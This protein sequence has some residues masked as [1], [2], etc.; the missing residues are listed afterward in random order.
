MQKIYLWVNQYQAPAVTWIVILV[1]GLLGWISPARAQAPAWQRAMSGNGNQPRASKS[2]A[3]ATA[4]DAAGN[5][6][7]TGL[8][9]GE[10][11]FGNI[12]LVGTGANDMFVAKWNTTT[13][14]W[15]WAFAETTHGTSGRSQGQS[16]AVSGNNVY[17]SGT[18]NSGN[19]ASFAGQVLPGAGTQDIFLAKYTDNGPSVT[20]GWATSVGGTGFDDGYGVAASGTSV[21]LTG[22]FVSGTNASIAGRTFAGTGDTDIFLAKYTDN[23]TSFSNG[24]AVSAGGTGA[25]VGYGV[26]ASGATVYLTGAFTSA[27]NA[28]IAGQVL[29][30]AGAQDIFLAKY[31]DNGATFAN[32][33]VLS[34]GGLG[35]EIGYGVAVGT[36]GVY[37]TG[38]TTTSQVRIAG[39]S[40]ATLGNSDIYLA[41]YTDNGPSFSNGWATSGGSSG[42]DGGFGVT[43]SGSD[44]YL[45]GSI[46]SFYGNAVLAGKTLP[47][48][49]GADDV[50]V[51]K[52]TDN[53]TSFTNRWASTGGGDNNDSGRG[54]AVSGASVYVAAFTT[55]LS[56]YAAFFGPSPGLLTPTNAGVLGQLQTSDGTWQRVDAPLHGTDSQVQSTTT[57]ANGDVFITGSFTGQVAFGATQLVSA[58]N[59]DIFVAKW[60]TAANT[61][62]WATRAGGIYGESGYG[63]AVNGHS[64]YVTGAVVTYTGYGNVTTIAGRTLISPDYNQEA[65]VAK[66]IDNGTGFT[67]GWAAIGG[68]TTGNDVG[69][70]LTVRGTNV[71]VTGTFDSGKAAS[72][73]GQTLAGAGGTDAFLAKYVDNGTSAGNG[74]AV[75]AGGTGADE[76]RGVAAEG[77]NVYSTGTFSSSTSARIAGQTLAGAGGTDA[78]LAKYVDNG[79]SA[80]NGWATSGGGTGNDKATG[81]VSSGEGIY[82]TGNFQSGT[83]ASVSG[84]TLAGAGGTDV[85]LAKYSDA[86]A[87]FSNGWAVSA[88]GT[89]ADA[90][91]ALAL[92]GRN[93]YLTGSFSATATVAGQALTSAGGLD[94]FLAKYADNGSPFSNGWATS[95]GGP[96]ADAGQGVAVSGP[97]VY[98][99]GFV[100]PRAAFGSQVLNYPTNTAINFLAQVNEPVP[101][102]T[103]FT[104]TA[105]YEGIIVSLTGTNLAGATSI[106]FAGTSNNTVSTDFVVNATGTQISNIIV[107][108]GTQ[109]GPISV[110]TAGGTG[111]S[112]A[113]F[114]VTPAVP[115]P[116]PTITALAPATIE[117]GVPGFTLSVTGTGFVPRCVVRFNGVVLPTTLASST[118][119]TALVP[120]SALA[121]AGSYPVTVTNPTPAGGLSAPATFVVTAPQLP[122][123][124]SFSPSSGPVG[125]ILTLTG[126]NLART[127]AITFT[128]LGANTVSSG[129]TPNAA[130]TQL[131]GVVVPAGAQTGPIRLTTPGGTATSATSF[132]VTNAGAPGITRFAPTSAVAGTS[133]VVT[134]TNLSGLTSLTVNGVA[135]PF[136]SLTASTNTSFAFPV[137][138]GATATGV[139]SVATAA[140]SL[141]AGTFRVLLRP[142]SSAPSF[143]ATR[144]S[145]ANS[146]VAVTF[147][148]PVTDA[149]LYIYSALAGG[150]KQGTVT[151]NGSTVSFAATPGTPRTP[152]QAGET[153]QVTV[154]A[155]AHNANNLLTTKRVFQFSAAV[156]GTG[157]GTFLA[158]SNPSVAAS[159]RAITTGDVDG[160]GDLDLLTGNVAGN[161]VSLLL[162]NG[163]GAFGT[164]TS[165]AVGTGTTDLAL[166]DV[167]GDGDLDLLASNYTSNTVSVRL[168]NGSGTFSS[169]QDVAIP[170]NTA[171]DQLA[172]GDVDGDGDLDL[173]V[174]T[175]LNL[176]ASVTLRLNGGDASGSNT[177]VYSG[178]QSIA[179]SSESRGVALAD[180]DGDGD[181]D[182]LAASVS[183]GFVQVRLNGGDATGSNTGVFSGSGFVG[184]GDTPASIAT[185]DLDGDGDLDLLTAN[186][187]S[188]N[189]SVR[190][191]NGTGDF[192]NS[193]TNVNVAVGSGPYNIALADV[194]ADGDLDL[195]TANAGF[196]TDGNSV[197]V[198]LNGGNATG[199]NT[200]VFS[201][202]STVAVGVSPRALTVGDFD[203]DGD[204]DFATPDGSIGQVSVRLNGG[205]TLA[206]TSAGAKPTFDVYPNPA[207]RFANVI[208]LPAGQP[209]ELLDAV[210]RIIGKFKADA[211]GKAVLTWP[212][213]VASGVYMLRA[214]PQV[215][216]L[217]IE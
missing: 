124:S 177:G 38:Y 43:T 91:T 109:T 82:L 118:Q 96:A 164:A 145:L 162:N 28:N 190:F 173:L 167:D 125:T 30:G 14:T 69:Y 138:A 148:E 47:K 161:T 65:F 104:P 134:G 169:T 163:T 131:M 86:G 84:R 106:T 155:T 217:T 7:I 168:N 116:V 201:N 98:A 146:A 139:I 149:G 158:G 44:V 20:P 216:R 174:G 67:N 102:V 26:A 121:T 156:G 130:G 213:S 126:T 184:V 37:V 147:S 193:T 42:A 186:F 56:S 153:V 194:D 214:G 16:I 4:T 166:A 108:S 48:G 19:A 81:L 3:M 199:S 66:Y 182:V 200:G 36:A 187:G 181:L 57:D 170:S 93:L 103:S 212:V 52:Y 100:T 192:I 127:S 80:G 73:A 202:G 107:P 205:T 75:S 211:S 204:L 209:L 51:A 25:D 119:L 40:L 41:K 113:V 33:W 137:P 34:E 63:I 9:Q 46:Q 117:A 58:G 128:G 120:A 140:G 27:K 95:G 6:Y 185:G 180:V 11:T 165:I 151:T 144:G 70:G 5:V 79:T 143:N 188:H 8:I 101:T 179:V 76:G 49:N 92:S 22:S 94:V 172:L 10:V 136:A 122:T 18:F 189:V 1:F 35:N 83:S 85:F 206:S 59:S 171:P 55:S 45:S 71:Y 114:T 178:G 29:P 13:S 89:G 129:F 60:N 111:A 208:G 97:Q 72:F 39:Q 183:N 160:D 21:Y 132:T 78:F 61:W 31:T 23:G 142:L 54:V 207:N 195:L 198:R 64:V 68:G 210:G 150:R 87:G 197:S 2:N 88:G 123:L 154:P 215:Q 175:G 105:G 196:G 141:S 62:A 53:G 17:V 77:A 90:G 112:T 157:R 50:F 159:S 115:N 99:S 191:N 74:W 24:W 135:V 12:R 32:S 133:V 152:F 110:T 15:A 176:T 203:G